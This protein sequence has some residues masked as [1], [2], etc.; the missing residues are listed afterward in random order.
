MKSHAPDLFRAFADPTRLRILHLLQ[1]HKEV[2]VCDLCAVLEEPQPKVSRHL[3]VLRDAGLVAARRDGKWMFYALAQA[4]TPLHRTLL[5]CVRTCLA[6]VDALA[7]DR[8]R[9][10]AL[11]PRVRCT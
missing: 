4:P 1:Q 8:E 10:A 7:A 5:R 2:C 9:L 3:G 6:D 11:A